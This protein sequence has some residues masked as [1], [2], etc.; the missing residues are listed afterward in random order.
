MTSNFALLTRTSAVTT[1]TYNPRMFLVE[2]ESIDAI[3]QGLR[4]THLEYWACIHV[5]LGQLKFTVQ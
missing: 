1:E 2:I 4:E 3:V 5:H